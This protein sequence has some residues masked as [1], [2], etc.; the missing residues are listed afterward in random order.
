MKRL[1]GVIFALSLIVGCAESEVADNNA[2]NANNANNGSCV[3]QDGDGFDGKTADCPDGED[4][5]DRNP[6]VNP[7]ATEIPGDGRDNDCVDGDAINDN[8]DCPDADNDNFRDQACG[9]RDC[10]DSNPDIKPR[11]VEIC[12]NADD[13]DCDG[14]AQECNENCTDMD[15]DGFGTAG[16][17]E[18]PGGDE[19]D[20]DD[21]NPEIYPGQTEICNGG[22]DDNC[23]DE[24]DECLLEGQVCVDTA[25]QGGAGSQC[26][27]NDDCGG[28]RLTCDTSTDPGICKVTEGG[29]CGDVSDCVDG[30]QCEANVCTGN[31]CATANCAAPYDVCDRDGGKCVECPHFDPSPTVQDAACSGIE[32]CTPGGWCA[33][34]WDVPN[35]NPV[36]GSTNDMLQVNLAIAQCFIDKVPAGEKDMC[37]AF[38]IFNAVSA[39]ITE[40]DV[41]D[42]YLDGLL[43]GVLTTAQDEALDDVW[44]PGLFNLKELSWK[45]DLVVGTAKEFC[46]W[47]EPGGFLGGEAVVV[48]RCDNFAP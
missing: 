6:D 3:D 40:S 22:V 39:D 41:E 15:Q 35:S 11:G 47:Y 32:Q 24:Q 30:L 44:G 9:G 43:D 42:A 13:E 12:G 34:N 25:C 36:D 4:C 18:C 31:F 20:C 46:V 2:N 19:V 8:T 10:D 14:T 38:F 17:T 1:L 23:N 26:A 5:N 29:P 16:S 28:S 21:T 33:E 27:N 45:T 37:Y 7:N 48:D